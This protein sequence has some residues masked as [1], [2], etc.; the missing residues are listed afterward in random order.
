MLWKEASWTRRKKGELE[1]L[2][3]LQE[4]K[5]QTEEKTRGDKGK[6]MR[7]VRSI[8]GRTVKDKTKNK[9]NRLNERKTGWRNSMT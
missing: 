5:D 6:R 3:D 8:E 9:R 1:E 4:E 2:H 7:T